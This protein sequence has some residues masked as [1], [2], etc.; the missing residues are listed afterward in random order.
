SVLGIPFTTSQ[1]AALHVCEP[2]ADRYTGV[3]QPPPKGEI[4]AVCA[5]VRCIVVFVMTGLIVLV[6]R[7]AFPFP[8][9]RTDPSA[10]VFRSAG[11]SIGLFFSYPDN[12]ERISFNGSLPSIGDDASLKR[13][14]SNGI[15]TAGGC[16]LVCSDL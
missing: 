1:I 5:F 14:G 2:L 6:G 7:F 3:C 4:S 12:P 9:I 13:K 8:S 11:L 15:N 16:L 10:L